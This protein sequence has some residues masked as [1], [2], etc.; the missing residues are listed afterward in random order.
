[1]ELE[2]EEQTKP[3]VSRRKEIKNRAEINKIESKQLKRPIKL[4]ADINVY[5]GNPKEHTKILLELINK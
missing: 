2:R 5:I 4:R 3:Q 1:M